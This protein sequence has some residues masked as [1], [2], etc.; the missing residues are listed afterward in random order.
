MRSIS[1]KRF[2]VH[3]QP[4]EVREGE[5]LWEYEEMMAALAAS[6]PYERIWT[7][8]EGD[9]GR[10]WYAVPGFHVVNAIGF[11]LTKKP[12]TDKGRDALYFRR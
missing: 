4:E 5:T 12:W 2:W 1:E 3:F 9:D 11:C 6:I 7:V 10:D 8:V